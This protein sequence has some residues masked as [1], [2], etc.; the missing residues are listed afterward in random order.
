MS[1]PTPLFDSIPRTIVTSILSYVTSND[2]LNFRIV[3]RSFYEIVHEADGEDSEDESLW[4]L[5]L[6]RDYQFED[7]GNCLSMRQT[8]TC[9]NNNDSAFLSTKDMFT[10][11]TCFIA[12][13]HWRKIDHHIHH[14]RV[15]DCRIKVNVPQS[16]GINGPYF[17][18]ACNMWK[19]I[20]E[21][22]GD[23]SKSGTVGR[24]IKESLLPGKAIEP[25]F[26][27]RRYDGEPGHTAAFKAIYAF[28]SGQRNV[29][30]DYLQYANPFGGLFGGWSAYDMVSNVRMVEIGTIDPRMPL[31]TIAADINRSKAFAL[32]MR[33]GRVRLEGDEQL[34]AI[35]DLVQPDSALLLWFEE[36]A[37]RL[38]KNFYSVGNIQDYESILRYPNIADIENCSR[39]VTRGVEVVASSIFA[40]EMEMFVYSIRIRLL[41]PEDEGYMSPEERGFETCQLISRHWI[42]KDGSNHTEE[43]RGDGVIGQYPLLHEGGFTNFEGSGIHTLEEQEHSTDGTFS[44]QSASGG[45]SG[46]FEGYLQFR[47]GR[48]EQPTGEDFDV[49]VAPFP[50]K[51][52]QFMY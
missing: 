29:D 52:T 37:S 48:L 2:W 28:Y 20:E 12:W 7:V 14:E 11:A 49:R 9:S 40:L 10:A 51:L 41:V 19:K 36:H 18:R 26:Y 6:I 47:P 27:G 38:T 22:C 21:W 8:F 31:L 42:I 17:I 4:K 5:A 1:N 35:F 16:E 13:K 50:L 33:S 15:Q 39:A 45:S 34:N 25:N 23:K 3:S 30:H 32:D 24:D 43:V 46:S 44:Y